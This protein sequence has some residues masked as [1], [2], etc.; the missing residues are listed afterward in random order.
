MDYTS[1][2]NLAYYLAQR[3]WAD[4]EQH[5][6]GIGSL[7]L[8]REVAAAWKQRQRTKPQMITSAAG[9]KSVI[10]VER[11]GYRQCL[12]PVRALYLDLSQWAIEDPGRWARWAAP[13]PV[14]QEEIS[15]RKF[16]RHRKARMDARTRER[17]PVLPVLVRTADERRKNAAALLQ[18]ARQTPPGQ[19]FTAAGQTLTR[20]VTKTAGEDLG[21][22]PGRRQAPRSR[23]RRRPRVLGL[24]RRRSPSPHR[25]PGR[26]TAG[27]QPPQPDPVPPARHRRDRAAAADRPIEDRRGKTPGR[28]PGAGGRAVGN[29]PPDPGTRRDSPARSRLRPLRMPM[30]AAVCR[31]FSSAGSPARSGRS[32]TPHSGT[33]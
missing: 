6:P 4:L 7:H 30:A 29:H 33:C 15:Q 5:H 23:S 12:T 10:M 11:V 24:G 14:S 32:A 26:G 22:R 17:L 27:D 25:L 28:L 9:E 31:S 3:F 13:C 20:P 8:P 18:A 19:P 21:R 2:K 1:L 16:Q